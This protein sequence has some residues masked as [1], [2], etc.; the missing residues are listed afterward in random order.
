[1]DITRRLWDWTGAGRRWLGRRGS[2]AAG[3]ERQPSGPASLTA[4]SSEFRKEV[5]EVATGVHVAIGYGLANSILIEGDDGNIVV[6]ALESNGAARP[7]RQAFDQIAGK[8]LAALIY[9]HN[10]A[11]HVFGSLAMAADDKPEV[12][13]HR[14]TAEHILRILGVLRPAIFT[15]SMRQFGVYLGTDDH[16]N[17]G[18]G[19][20]LRY[21]AG[22]AP[23]VLW[24]TKE[25]DDQLEERIA[26]V[27]VVLGHV[28]GE[29][30]DHLYVWL[31]E[32]RILI[33]GDNFYRAFPNLYAIRGT[34]YRDVMDWVRS[35]DRM[36]S[37]DA[38]LLVPCH[39]RPLRGAE[40]IR[41]AL[42]DYRDAI[43]FVHDQTVRR[44]NLGQTP[45][46]IA[47]ELRLP[48][49]LASRPYLREHYGR[50]SWSAR[51]I[52]QGY[53]GW[54]DGDAATL[55]P[56]APRLRGE[57]MIELAGGRQRLLEEAERACRQGEPSWAAELAGHLLAVHPFDGDG[58]RIRAD[59]LRA[60]GEESISANGR[61]Y[62]LTQAKEADG[63]LALPRPQ[64]AVSSKHVL[65]TLPMESVLR[66][67]SV[68]L[69]GEAAS[70]ID[71]VIGL[72]FTD[73][74]ES[75]TL[76]LR[77]GVA[78]IC[79]ERPP[80]AEV[81]IQTTSQVWK[82]LLIG[83][84]SAARALATQAIRIEGSGI[85]LARCLWLFRPDG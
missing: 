9:T 66:A 78:V 4:H 53:L 85:S 72:H 35:L 16:I 21:D 48:E 18:I 37:L 64:P 30:P 8:P 41:Q 1:M 19:P 34:A 43:Q 71:T 6:D 44:M 39:G 20:R 17:A 5:L 23:A 74:N 31:P 32:R 77:R 3:R 45:N 54:F 25:V 36:L 40:Q 61:N 75:W 73:I 24:P 26:G 80:Q 14:S 59:A 55:D 7:V 10:H 67:M 42:S 60:L 15:R 76:H 33:P 83:Q 38:E 68:S 51:A 28:P 84:R 63:S 46:Q 12:Y 82:E 79:P 56:P 11:D 57:R 52:Y 2:A 29:T 22:T 49:H 58:R 81:R 47:D 62:H 65:S 69:D 13:A 50:V 27:N 70:S